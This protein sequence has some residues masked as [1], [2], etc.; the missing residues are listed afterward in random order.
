VY[1]LKLVMY[2]L[3]GAISPSISNLTNLTTLVLS[4]NN[5][6]S[7]IPLSLSDMDNLTAID[8]SFNSLGGSLLA[9][10]ALNQL[11]SLDLAFNKLTGTLSSDMLALP[12]LQELDL[13]FNNISG[14]LVINT[15][16]TSMLRD[17]SLWGNQL[18]GRIPST[19]SVLIKLQRLI[20]RNNRFMHGL[21]EEI[22][23]LHHLSYFDAS[24]NCFNGSLLQGLNRLPALWYLNLDHNQFTGELP[25]V[26]ANMSALGTLSLSN[27]HLVGNIPA[28]YVEMKNL[29]TLQVGGNKLNGAIPEFLHLLPNLRVLNLSSNQFSESI[30]ATLYKATNLIE[31]SLQDNKITGHLSP[32]ISGLRHLLYLQL[33]GNHIKGRPPT[34]LSLLPNLT[35]LTLSRNYF[36]GS[37]TGLFNPVT[38]SN[39]RVIL[40]NDNKFSGDLPG[41]L[42]NLPMLT[43][44]V[45]ES[46]CFAG[47]LPDSVCNA[48]RMTTLVLDGLSA[49]CRRKELRRL[50]GS[51]AYVTKHSVRGHLPKCLF[52]LPSL[53]TLHLSGNEFTSSIPEDVQLS[54]S[55]VYLSLAHNALTGTIPRSIQEKQWEQLDLSYN[56]LDGTLVRSFATASTNAT[57]LALKH[58]LTSYVNQ[59]A[60]DFL[61]YYQSYVE[62]TTVQVFLQYV[63]LQFAV[64]ESLQSL[65]TTTAKLYLQNNRLSGAIPATIHDVR[66]ISVLGT[67]IFACS[68]DHRQL[69]QHN[70]DK[71][72]YKCG[73]QSFED[74]YYI[75]LSVV[76]CVVV[77]SLAVLFPDTLARGHVRLRELRAYIAVRLDVVAG[78]PPPNCPSTGYSL[79][80]IA[81][82]NRPLNVILYL[83]TASLLFSLCVLLPTYTALS[84]QYRTYTYTY[85][86]V[87]SCAFLS[88]TVPAVTE[89]VLLVVTIVSMV[90]GFRLLRNSLGSKQTV[91]LDQVI[92]EKVMAVDTTANATAGA[93]IAALF[94]ISNV[95]LVVLANLVFVY[96]SLKSN[97]LVQA[98]AQLYLAVFKLVWNNVLSHRLLRFT[99]HYVYR[100]FNIDREFTEHNFMTLLMVFAILNNVVIPLAVIAAVSPSCFAELFKGTQNDDPTISALY[101]REYCAKYGDNQCVVYGVLPQ[102]SSF[103]PPFQYDFQCSSSLLTS[104]APTFISMCIITTIVL[105]VKDYVVMQLHRRAVPGSTCHVLLDRALPRLLKPVR[106]SDACA[107]QITDTKAGRVNAPKFTPSADI[108]RL[109]VN[110]LA[111][112]ATMLTFGAAF[113]PVAV[114]VAVSIVSTVYVAKFRIGRF[115]H[116]AIEQELYHFVHVVNIECHELGPLALLLRKALWL[117]L[118]VKCTF[119]AL[120][121]FDM[122][123]DEVGYSD[124]LWVLIV[125]PVLPLMT[126]ALPVVYTSTREAMTRVSEADRKKRPSSTPTFLSGSHRDVELRDLSIMSLRAPSEA[127]TA[128]TSGAEGRVTLSALH[129]N[130]AP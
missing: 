69:P 74:Y 50:P 100:A 85:A 15:G 129:G 123:G 118:I 13:S 12:K 8:L 75:W 127:A 19:L 83:T 104:Y 89:L 78:V 56:R 113:P 61:A 44:F 23:N 110:V 68:R 3:T 59:Q 48:T 37:L 39:L 43:S 65:N 92:V 117:L 76:G 7:T 99:Y 63:S 66:T 62:D 32:A 116:S 22:A 82:A 10:G 126:V 14:A 93:L 47:R 87:V 91:Q 64:A 24:D 11:T 88:G 6:S 96:A 5:L 72:S 30:P 101:L 55:L 73:S 111:Q 124:A 20:L 86:Y 42:F 58:E 41:E 16:N 122:W 119:T 103:V 21:P 34:E 1:S 38:Q 17:L 120:F 25:S 109:M 84:T 57:K 130:S 52:A 128:W 90:V 31:L 114:A 71:D 70:H 46:N 108:N 81:V 54:P 29:S 35:Q 105:P 107:E 60:E 45:A 40:L 9:L 106:P 26:W 102:S 27:N 33:D 49:N 97:D 4:Y 95:A 79:A 67:N 98:F 28:E 115:L 121:V 53:F 51:T 18:T 36:T 80:N 112:Y 125:I 2:N 94:A 77:V